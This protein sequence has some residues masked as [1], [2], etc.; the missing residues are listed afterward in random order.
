MQTT[1]VFATPG[2]DQQ[3]LRIHYED[4]L[5]ATARFQRWPSDAHRELAERRKRWLEQAGG[6]QSLSERGQQLAQTAAANRLAPDTTADRCL[7]E[8]CN[9]DSSDSSERVPTEHGREP[10]RAAAN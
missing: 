9:T 5:V 7:C 2:S 8:R 3:S 4:A 6:I 1:T 10:S